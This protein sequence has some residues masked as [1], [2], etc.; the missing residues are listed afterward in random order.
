MALIAERTGMMAP[1]R[2]WVKAKRPVWVCGV[3][4][5]EFVISPTCLTCVHTGPGCFYC[6]ELGAMVCLGGE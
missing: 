2:E 6:F 1:L 3:R 4:E 5:H